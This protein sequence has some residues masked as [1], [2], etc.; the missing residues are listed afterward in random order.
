MKAWVLHDVNRIHF[1][2]VEKPRP[3]ENEVLV[4]V[5]AAGICGSDIPRIYKTGAH[6]HPLVP[7]HEFSGQVIEVGKRAGTAWIGKR[8][9]IFPLIPCGTCTACQKRHYELCRNYSYLG[10][11]RNGGFAEYVAVPEWNLIELPDSVPYEEAAMLEPMAVAVHAM[12]RVQLHK[13][14][15]AVILGLGT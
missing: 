1:E 5:K 14:D 12:R 11:R 3:A 6:V 13:N 15:T 7:G 9:G 2:E 8:V 10:S 4:S